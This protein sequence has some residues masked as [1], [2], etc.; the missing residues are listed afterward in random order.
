MSP[1]QDGVRALR[2]R[3]VTAAGVLEDAVV[4]IQ[5][6]LITE[7]GDPSGT[8]G[9]ER[10]AA[11]IVPGFVDLH[12]HGGGGHTFDAAEP[13]QARG[14]ME[15]HRTHG[16]TTML[17]S[18]ATASPSDT[19]ARTAALAPL[20]H[21]GDLAGVHLEG[22][23][24]STAR[25]GAQN[26]A[27]LR[28]PD[29]AE[30]ADLIALGIV[31]AVTMAPELPGA[32]PAI[33]QLRAHGITVA[34]GHTDATYEQTLAAVEAGATIATHLGNAMRPIHHRD[35]GPIV[36]L[37]QSP[38]VICEQVADGVHLHDGMLRH[39]IQAAGPARVALV[40]D[41]MAAA[42]M[43]DGEFDLAGQD[44][45]VQDGVARL[46]ASGA[47]AG[48]TLTMAEALRHTVRC[49]A[50]IVEAVTMASA[51]PARALGLEGSIGSI[52]AGMR[53]DLVLLDD[54][55]AVTAVLRDGIAV[56]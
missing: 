37:L 11:W 51:T 45:T 9:S 35:P 43:P 21:S 18:L 55:L 12:V 1:D 32:L 14:A 5:D 56:R 23:Y 7:V 29:P 33:A 38:T 40:T 41:A 16:T 26:P 15:F 13:E 3:V 49:G 8:D 20:V 34:V 31:R 44:V 17:A 36:A 2:G 53:A 47:I 6:G 39:V 46:A 10:T 22:P 48:S 25:C 27:H 42:G 19:Y 52:A 50:S 4:R 30:I 54:N 24:L 28:S